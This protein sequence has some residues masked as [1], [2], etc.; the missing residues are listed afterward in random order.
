MYE[1]PAH[2]AI[3]TGMD[4]PTIEL[5]VEGFPPSGAALITWFTHRYG[6]LPGAAELGQLLNAMAIR[7]SSRPLDPAAL[8]VAAPP[9]RAKPIA[10]R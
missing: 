5:P 10:G 4:T 1:P 8:A 2:P 9:A 7:D 3:L 6:R